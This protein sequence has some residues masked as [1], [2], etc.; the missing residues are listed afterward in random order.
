MSSWTLEGTKGREILVFYFKRATGTFN[1]GLSI[2]LENAP[3]LVW[4]NKT[5]SPNNFI[6]TSASWY[7]K[8]IK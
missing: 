4:A 2:S 3:N 6:F 1:S 5:K 7:L 8:S